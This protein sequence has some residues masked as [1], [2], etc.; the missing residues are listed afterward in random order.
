MK[1]LFVC[2][3]FPYPPTRGGKIRP[4]NVIRHLAR[5]HDVTVASVAR[6]AEEARAGAGLA[7]H[8]RRIVVETLSPGPTI[9]RMLARLP[10]PTPSS[11]GYFHSPRLARR[12]QRLLATEAF[13]LI[14]VHCAFVAPYVSGAPGVPKILDFGDMDSQKW[15]AYAR[16][17]AF[18]LSLGYALEGRKLQRA[19][20][21]LARRFDLC[22]CTTLAEL[23]TL[24]AYGT[25]VPTGWFPN[26]VDA[27]Y[28]RPS[29]APYDPDA[30]VFVGRMDYFPNQQG[31][32]DFC[33][34]TWPLIRA[35]RPSASLRIV[36]AA[37]SRA[38]RDLAR[39]PGVTV[40]GDVPDVR[41]HVAT[42]AVTV[43]PLAIA[44]GT[45][46]K[47]LEAMAMGV[48]TVAT[49]LAA[50]GVDAEAGVDIVVA[51]TPEQYAE[52]VLRLLA[53]PSARRQ[54]AEA[55]RRRVVTRHSWARSMTQLDGLIERCLRGRRPAGSHVVS[56]TPPSPA[57]PSP[58]LVRAAAPVNGGRHAVR[59]LNVLFLAKRFPYP[60]DTGGKIR[61]G[62][63]LEH[64][65]SDLDVTLVSNI[66]P[67]KDGPHLGRVDRL[68]V[69]FHGVPW[70]E[71]TKYSLGFYWRVARRLFSRYP[72]TVI[73]DYSAP[74]AA[75]LRDL[76]STR[77]Y[78]L[79]V[80]DFVQPSLNLHGIA[81]PPRLLFQHNVES[82]IW[83][84]HALACR[85]PVLRLFW[86]EQ[87]RKME[88][89]EREACRRFTGVVAVSEADQAVFRE[90]GA[91]RVF[92][93]PTAVDAEYFRPGSA[94][95]DGARLVFTGSMDWLPNEDAILFFADEI[96]PRIAARVP[97]VTL[98]VVGRSPS[99]RL[100]RR[101][102]QRPAVTITGRVEDIRP[103][104]ERA[105]VYVVP[106]R[107][108]GG[109]RIKLYEAMAMGKAIV[110]TPVGAEG[111]PVRDAEHLLLADK[112][113]AFA[114]AVVELLVDPD[115][116]LRL[117]RAARAFVES[118]GTW[119]AAAAAF[120]AACRAVTDGQ[121]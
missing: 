81:G 38:I 99:A 112:P 36:G 76:V 55:A 65:R 78:D 21:R 63:L 31:I 2:H 3:R 114:D 116:R 35:R 29:E 82:M 49:P 27:E 12:L 77:H 16:A 23:D 105:A 4:F 93:I 11:M 80:C 22:T 32:L 96:L 6:S 43:A 1:I 119:P 84:R 26:G 97:D 92:A 83:K 41:P 25:G 60:M 95:P 56:A 66:E 14:F 20:A 44:R 48:P 47:I 117:G 103:H 111:L 53:D 100:R 115:R 34:A 64:L 86:L 70:R 75:A 120:A 40:T 7:A 59:R 52:A 61:T 121:P 72:V 39:L 69:E 15:L 91:R 37:P 42:A 73:N 118:E 50:R 9:A 17:R 98:T 109:T 19:E 89:F 106:L 113:Q 54:V 8:C 13:D 67:G 88:R 10:T 71:P 45:Q 51:S 68:C 110:S 46:N 104:V 58:P 33:A 94:V 102:E 79:I 101:L 108:G 90:F 28:F 107:I 30:V 87:W 57:P 5:E 85:H 24:D 74:L 18:P 62:M